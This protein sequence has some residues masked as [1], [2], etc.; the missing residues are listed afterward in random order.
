MK[1]IPKEVY[2]M[3][4][5]EKRYKRG[6]D[7]RMIVTG[8]VLSRPGVDMSDLVV[9]E[10]LGLDSEVTREMVVEAQEKTRGEA[11]KAAWKFL[12]ELTEVEE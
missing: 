8:V 11:R 3:T 5:Y 12:K 9:V 6:E 4:G 2:T 7:G 1:D 10:E